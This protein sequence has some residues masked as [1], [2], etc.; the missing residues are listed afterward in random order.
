MSSSLNNILK[1]SLKESFS[2]SYKTIVSLFGG[3]IVVF[4]ILDQFKYKR[5]TSILFGVIFTVTLTIAIFIYTAIKNLKNHIKHLET[6]KDQDISVLS[7]LKKSIELDYSKHQILVIDDNPVDVKFIKT[8]RNR[9]YNIKQV[10]DIKSFDEVEK[11]KVI[12][13]DIAGVGKHFNSHFQ[14]GY[15]IQQITDIYPLKYLIFY[16]GQMWDATFGKILKLVDDTMMKMDTVDDWDEKLK[17]AFGAIGN[18]VHMW[19]KKIHKYLKTK[20]VQ[21]AAIFEIKKQYILAFQNH[22]SSAQFDKVLDKYQLPKDVVQSIHQLQ[23]FINE[24]NSFR[25]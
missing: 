10:K 24:I 15:L 4:L 20:Q 5:G 23:E 22:D 7:N 19:E 2:L 17:L 13:C 21:S 16:S 8:L 11:Y 1:Q 14:G 25:S 12:I 3:F 9:G 6:Q 18:P